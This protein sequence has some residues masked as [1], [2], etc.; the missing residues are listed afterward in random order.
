MS[1]VRPVGNTTAP[2]P[3][4]LSMKNKLI[5]LGLVAGTLLLTTWTTP[6]AAQDGF[7][8]RS[9]VLQFTVRAGANQQ[10]A[11]GELFDDFRSLFTMDRDDFLAP[12]V[13]GDVLFLA[14]RR[15]DVAIGAGHSLSQ[16]RSEYRDWEGSDNLPIEQDTKLRVVPVTLTVRYQLNERGRT[17]GS[18]AWIPRTFTPYVGGGVGVTWYNLSQ[19]GEFIDIEDLSIF[20]RHMETSGTTGGASLVAGF[21]R[22]FTPVAGLNA[23]MRYSW[24]SA[25]ATPPWQHYDSIDLSGVQV[26]LGVSLRL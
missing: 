13:S 3:V 4:H 9:P 18:H 10:L 7:R 20:G 5:P 12:T 8:L 1:G 19:S 26:S 11:R 6:A 21:D 23:E 2:F 24:G 17:V 14:G 15:F 25:A 16:T 22:W